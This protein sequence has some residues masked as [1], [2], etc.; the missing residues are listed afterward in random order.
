MFYVA[1][2]DGH[3]RAAICTDGKPNKYGKPK[4]FS[5][6]KEAK[7]WIIKNSY[8]GMSFRYEIVPIG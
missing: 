3:W 8:V 7:K 1:K 4:T 6:E 2:V 5:S